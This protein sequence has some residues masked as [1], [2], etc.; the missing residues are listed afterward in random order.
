MVSIICQ[1]SQMMVLVHNCNNWEKG[2][3]MVIKKISYTY[4]YFGDRCEFALLNLS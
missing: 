2:I 4:R 1:F 3:I